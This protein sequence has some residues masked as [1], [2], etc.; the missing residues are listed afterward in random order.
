MEQK[1][2]HNFE[3]P[4]FRH[5]LRA[6]LNSWFG[7]R[8]MKSRSRIQPT[9]A[10][11]LLDLGAGEHRTEGWIHVDF[12]RLS[13]LCFWRRRRAKPFPDVQ[14]DL[15][16]PLDCRSDS[17]DGVFCSHTLEHLQPHA[18][19]ALLGEVFRVLKPGAWLRIGVPDLEKYVA[20]YA[21]NLGLPGFEVFCS[22]A[23][24]IGYLT[25]GHGH[26]SVW[27][28]RTLA[29]ELCDAGFVEVRRVAFGREGTDRRLIQEAPHREW[30]TLIMEA[31][32]PE[33]SLAGTALDGGIQV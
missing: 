26:R 22:G 17:I 7:R 16:Y 3:A 4:Q 24:A 8:F 11:A 28:G 14:A 15:R 30:E 10:P 25:Q 5:E 13:S 23:E 32:K 20:F 31:R 2:Y 21:G 1:G 29:R 12:F 6:E 9:Q 19:L 18:A 33:R 27:D